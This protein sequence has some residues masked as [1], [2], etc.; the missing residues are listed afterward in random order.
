MEMLTR[1]GLLQALGAAAAASAIPA[2]S[3]GSAAAA[4]AGTLLADMGP[5][6]RLKQMLAMPL[7]GEARRGLA[8][9][10]GKDEI[11]EHFNGHRYNIDWPEGDY[12]VF[13]GNHTGDLFVYRVPE[14]VTEVDLWGDLGGE[15][16]LLGARAQMFS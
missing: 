4:G 7:D 12:G 2:G 10:I 16:E 5:L 11:A 13:V 6:E 15:P 8:F 3:A 9:M 1:R 14:D